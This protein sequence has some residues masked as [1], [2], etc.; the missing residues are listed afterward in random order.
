MKKITLFF[1]LLAIAAVTFCGCEWF[2]P[3]AEEGE[4]TVTVIIDLSGYDGEIT[5]GEGVTP[6]QNKIKTIEFTTEAK[7]VEDLMGEI[8]EEGFFSYSGNK[9]LAGLFLTEIDSVIIEDIMS[10]GFF[11]YA[12]DAENTNTEWG[13]Y[14]F[15]GKTLNST[16]VGVTEM[17]VKNG[18]KYAFVYTEYSF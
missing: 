2:K 4:K 18:C 12:D 7:R 3:P 10:E 5:V 13:S 9:S 8:A 17:P 15:D 1:A 14:Q 6:Y 16:T 11:F